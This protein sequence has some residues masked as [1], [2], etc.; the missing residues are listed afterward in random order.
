LKLDSNPGS[1]R[2]ESGAA[3]IQGRQLRHADRAWYDTVVQ[4]GLANLNALLR[5]AGLAEQAG[6]AD[7]AQRWLEQAW[8][9]NQPSLPARPS[10][11]RALSRGVLNPKKL[12]T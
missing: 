11:D 9:K 7:Q 8:N 10:S 6:Q 1:R 4:K 5:L 2:T 12:S 3:G